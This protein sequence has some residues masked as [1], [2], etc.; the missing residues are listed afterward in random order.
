VQCALNCY[1]RGTPWRALAVTGRAKHA[2]FGN[3]IDEDLTSDVQ[4]PRMATDPQL[5]V[6]AAASAP[7]K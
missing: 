2:A 7:P 3:A 1:W 5:A 6:E 4:W